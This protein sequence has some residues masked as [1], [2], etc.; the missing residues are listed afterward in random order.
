[1]GAAAGGARGGGDGDLRVRGVVERAAL[2]HHLHLA[3][4]DAHALRW[5]LVHGGAVRDP[6]GPALRRRHHQHG[7]GGHPLHLSAAPPDPGAVGGRR[8]GLSAREG[9]RASSYSGAERT[10]NVSTTRLTPLTS[11]VSA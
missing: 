10:S 2:R 7:A 6:V 4:G 8:Q 9:A 3:D 5:S 11:L 1:G